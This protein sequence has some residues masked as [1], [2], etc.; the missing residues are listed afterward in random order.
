MFV[1]GFK[2]VDIWMILSTFRVAA[3]N[4]LT[5]P[6]MEHQTFP[7]TL[8]NLVTGVVTEAMVKLIGDSVFQ[9]PKMNMEIGYE[10][11]YVM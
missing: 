2:S 7:W 8:S 3:F 5:T 6:C 9:P 11:Y 1:I 4:I 10:I